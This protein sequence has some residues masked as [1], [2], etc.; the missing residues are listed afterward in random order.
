MASSSPYSIGDMFG[1]DKQSIAVVYISSF[2]GISIY[3]WVSDHSTHEIW[4][5]QFSLYLQNE[6]LVGSISWLAFSNLHIFLL[7]QKVNKEA[8]KSL[9][10]IFFF[11]ESMYL[12][13]DAID[14]I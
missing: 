2:K 4:C 14:S 7:I 6:L 11:T 8:G 1:R 9:E 5:Q 3:P 13:V 12:D 10:M